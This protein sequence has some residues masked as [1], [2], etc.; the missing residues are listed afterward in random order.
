VAHSNRAAE[1][2][3]EPCLAVAELAG[4]RAKVANRFDFGVLALELV[5][6]YSPTR[7]LPGF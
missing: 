1:L 6:I 3:G 2:C 7:L 4:A 5:E